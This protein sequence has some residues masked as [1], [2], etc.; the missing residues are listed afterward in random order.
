[1]FLVIF[2]ALLGHGTVRISPTRVVNTSTYYVTAMACFG[3]ISA[4]YTNIAISVSIQRDSGVLKRTNGTPLPSAVYL[5]ARMLHSLLVAVL[6]VVITAAFGRLLY[7]ASIPTGLSLLRF[8]VMLLGPGRPA[9]G[10]PVL[11]LGTAY[12]IAHGIYR[13]RSKRVNCYLVRDGAALTLVDTGLPGHWPAIKAACGALGLDLPAIEA[14]LLTHVHSDHADSAERARA[15]ASAPVRLG[16]GDAELADG[17]TRGSIGFF[18]PDRGACFS[19]DALVTLNLLTGRRGPQLLGGAFMEDSRQAL[20]SLDQLAGLQAD[21]M[22]PGH[23]GQHPSATGPGR[24]RGHGTEA[25]RAV[26]FF[27]LPNGRG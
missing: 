19:G 13:V 17:R 26:L 24:F 15:E 2:T 5:G 25:Q 22:L 18:L 16:A 4:C 7:N 12:L 20:A 1:M 9:A 21:T 14:V 8:L 10:R 11:Q 23:G 3:V 6:L 27:D